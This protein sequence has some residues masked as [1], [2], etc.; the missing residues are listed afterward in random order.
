VPGTSPTV[1][2]ERSTPQI[3][4]KEAK[5]NIYLPCSLMLSAAEKQSRREIRN[6]SK[7]ATCCEMVSPG[8]GITGWHSCETQPPPISQYEKGIASE[9][10]ALPTEVLCQVNS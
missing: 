5:A 4:S 1:S 10:L 2:C 7:S 8:P 9:G 6:Q 3:A